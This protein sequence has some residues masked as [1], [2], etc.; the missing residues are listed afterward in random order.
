MK[1]IILFFILS[2][3]YTFK[4]CAQPY[5][6][7]DEYLS[8]V[9]KT[10]VMPGFSVVVVNNNGKI[11][12]SSYGFTE[13]GG[14]TAFSIE[15]VNPIGSLTKSITA[16]AVLQLVDRNQISL[17]TPVKHYIPEFTTANPERSDSIT[18][19]MLLN[20]TSGLTGHPPS[21]FDIS[22][23]SIRILVKNLS[24]TF[25]LTKPGVVYQY[26]N[27]GF[28]IA[29]LLVSIV[30]GQPYP[31]YVR[32]NI[33]Q[34]LSMEKSSVLPVE[35]SNQATGHFPGISRGIPNRSD[36]LV[37]GE[38]I[39]A[40]QYAESTTTDLANYLMMYLNKGAFY[41][42]RIL[43]ESFIEKMW[44]PEVEFVGMSVRDGGSGERY[45]YGLGWMISQI[46]ERK[47]FHH[48]GSTGTASSFTMVDS[49][50]GLAASL[51][52]NVDL[53]L[54]DRHQY[55]FGL[56]IINNVLH[57]AA[58]HS[59]TDFALPTEEDPT[60]NNFVLSEKKY[61]N[62]TG[63]YEYRTGGDNFVYFDRPFLLIT[64][65]KDELKGV[66]YRND[67]IIN[68]F[69]FDFV[70]PSL[71]IS[72]NI[73]SPSSL[74]FQINNKGRVTGIFALG[75]QLSKMDNPPEMWKEYQFGPLEFSV[76]DTLTVTVT[77]NGYQ[78][79]MPEQPDMKLELIRAEKVT[80]SNTIGSHTT[81][82]FN[83]IQWEKR[84]IF[85]SGESEKLVTIFSTEISGSIYQIYFTSL[86]NTHTYYLQTEI[87]RFLESIRLADDGLKHF[88]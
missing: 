7:I 32:T 66:I 17:D 42:N 10:H 46:D 68:E 86:A 59:T 4:A 18:V 80:Y 56:N 27:I 15:T 62:Y 30:S 79:S 55:P 24:N 78:L 58:G 77:E 47:V 74:Q 85:L 87:I 35:K 52:T 34:P 51:L 3:N 63:R 65:E 73:A 21:T 75:I 26:S 33:L 54:L 67:Q 31:E 13:A 41:S 1:Y 5:E 82:R 8:D 81:S 76:P 70:T 38:F 9:Y 44:H 71:A 88:R 72:R 22:E 16:L 28:G 14:S 39:A 53:T 57:L 12:Q 29:G 45:Q 25:I 11:F 50:N 48:G 20:N 23:E 49:E 2:F 69:L 64:R 61:D 40:G 37:S 6:S 83:S 84:S 36:G 60:K 43:S 19:R